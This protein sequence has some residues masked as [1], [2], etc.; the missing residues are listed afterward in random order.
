MFP[1][2][3]LLPSVVERVTPASYFIAKAFLEKDYKEIMATKAALLPP[4]QQPQEDTTSTDLVIG[5]NEGL[6]TTSAIFEL[7]GMSSAQPNLEL[8]TTDPSSLQN[9]KQQSGL[10][11][12][13]NVTSNHNRNQ[14]PQ[15]VPM[16]ALSTFPATDEEIGLESM[17]PDKAD[18]A[19]SGLD[20]PMAF[21]ND[22]SGNQAFLSSNNAFDGSNDPNTILPGL[23][24]YANAGGDEF[25]MEIQQTSNN[26]ASQRQ[27]GVVGAEDTTMDDL[28]PTESNFHD[29][30]V[31]SGNFGDDGEE[32]LLNDVEIEEYDSWFT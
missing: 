12:S 28:P 32:D 27:G 3:N 30:F 11:Q 15:S 23:E 8:H 6:S 31:D 16:S 1:S 5:N 24:S 14:S 4:K 19:A 22:E 25:N 10:S 29:L 13:D 17:F 7:K 9:H 20:I 26:T 18:G 21:S 2:M